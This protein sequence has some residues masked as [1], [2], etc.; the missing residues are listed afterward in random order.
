M[1]FSEK[2][3]QRCT[4]DV[5]DATDATAFTDV[6]DMTDATETTTST[7]QLQM[8]GALATVVALVAE[9]I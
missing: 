8:H 1:R 6:T 7:K 2:N 3:R 9:G 4:T 5:T